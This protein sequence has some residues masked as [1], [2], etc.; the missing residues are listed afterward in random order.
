MYG[1]FPSDIEQMDAIN[2]D[3]KPDRTG[4]PTPEHAK[5]SQANGVMMWNTLEFKEKIMKWGLLCAMTKNCI[6]PPSTW[7][8]SH[9][10]LNAIPEKNCPK[11]TESLK[12][13]HM[14]HRYDQSVFNIL[15]S[16]YYNY[17]SSMYQ[18]PVDDY[19]LL[20]R[21]TRSGDK[22]RKD[23]R[24]IIP[25]YKESVDPKAQLKKIQQAQ[26][27]KEMDNEEKKANTEETNETE[28]S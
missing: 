7:K 18:V 14:C 8:E 24:K 28:I 12:Q 1:Y 16:N 22:I 21:P 20:G 10:L 9:G 26:Q 17:N 15:L 4:N 19:E 27:E 6:A 5:M 2:E 11:N 3:V 25:S 13:K 23:P